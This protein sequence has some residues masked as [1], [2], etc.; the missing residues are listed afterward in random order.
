MPHALRSLRGDDE[1]NAELVM[2]AGF[3]EDLA[4]Q[5]N[6]VS[7]R[8]RGLLTQI[9]LALERAVATRRGPEARSLDAQ[10]TLDEVRR[11]LQDHAGVVATELTTQLAPALL[12]ATG[13]WRTD[14]GQ[15]HR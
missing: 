6:R 8:I 9:H 10:R 12:R 1:L 4:F 3:D 7:N 15:D 14:R 11:R 5:I 2:L 13:L